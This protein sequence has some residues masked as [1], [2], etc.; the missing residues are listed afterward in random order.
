M[1]KIIVAVIA[2]MFA[3]ATVAVAGVKDPAQGPV[4]AKVVQAP[5]S[6]AKKAVKVKK[7][8]KVKAVVAP[9]KAE[10]VK[11]PAAVK[12]EVPVKK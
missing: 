10:A 11:A 7:A 9:V 4:V 2:V 12:V 8:K 6:S 3:F 1:K 5:I